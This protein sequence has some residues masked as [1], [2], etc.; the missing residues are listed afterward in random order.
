MDFGLFEQPTS[1]YDANVASARLPAAGITAS[2]GKM[3]DYEQQLRSVRGITAIYEVVSR[4]MPKAVVSRCMR[5]QSS[6]APKV[7]MPK[8]EMS[9]S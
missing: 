1:Q 5:A 2:R 4:N 7:E 3:Q 9:S 6:R 8:Y